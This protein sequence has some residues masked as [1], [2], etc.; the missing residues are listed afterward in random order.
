MK[1][2]LLAVNA[3]KPGSRI[4]EFAGY[5]GRM[6]NATLSILFLENL[7]AE[8]R[9]VVRGLYGVT[10]L[11]W[12][13]DEDKPEHKAK[14]QLIDNNIQ[15]YREA[16]DIAGVHYSFKREAGQPSKILLE[17]S[18]FADLLIMDA[19][20]SFKKGDEEIPSKFVRH[21][22][23]HAGCPVMIA[24]ANFHHIN[25]VIFAYDE[26]QSSLFAIRQFSYL[27]PAFSELPLRVIHVSKESSWDNEKKVKLDHLLKSYYSNIIYE[28]RTGDAEDELFSYGL[29]LKDIVVVMGA[30]GRNQFSNFMRHST[31]E[32][33]IKTNLHSIFIAHK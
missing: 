12:D 20:L 4:L 21:I 1:K 24:P 26:S 16:C 2:I 29:K 6:T 9:I 11:D 18:Q 33:V 3:Q 25:E 13:I 28:I 31:A 19:D 27:F 23:E 5:L 8:E 14:M 22:L 10:Y 32:L 15:M 30:Y 17:E 7:V